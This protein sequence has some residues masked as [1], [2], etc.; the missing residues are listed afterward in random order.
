M[1]LA[2]AY[3]QII[4]TTENIAG[5]ISSALV[6][7]ASSAGDEAGESAGSALVDKIKKIVAAAGIGMA[8]KKGFDAIGDL[9]SYGDTIDK[10][11]QKI[12]ISAKAYQEWDAVLQH[13]GTSINTMQAAMKKMT[14]AAADGS[15]AFG[16]LGISQEE[17][18]SMSQE[19]LFARVIEGL[20]GMEE[21]TE[22]AALAQDLL[23][24]GA[25]EMAALL[26]TSAE[27]T[28]K[29]KDAVND[30]GGVMSDDAVKASAAYQ[31]ALQDMQTAFSGLGRSLLSEFLPGLT[32]V[33]GGIT[34]LFAG[35]GAGVQTVISGI[36]T[37]LGTFATAVPQFLQAGANIIMNVI[38]G[39]TAALPGLA[40]TGM[41][42]IPKVITGLLSQLP[43]LIKEGGNILQQFLNT[44]LSGLPSLMTGGTSMLGSVV[45]GIINTLPEIIKSAV[46]VVMSLLNTIMDNLPAILKA[47]IE[48]VTNIVTGIIDTLPDVI[49]AALEMVKNFLDQV[50]DN[51]PNMLQ[52]GTEIIANVVSG[53]ISS[54]PQI[55]ASAAS[56]AAEFIATLVSN[57]P[58]FLSK[59]VEILGKVVAGIIQAIPQIVSAAGSAMGD[60][61]STITGKLPEVLGKGKE[62]ITNLADG[63]KNNIFKIVN[64]VSSIFSDFK[65][66]ITGKD[67]GSIG[68]N[69]INGV[70]NGITNNLGKLKEAAKEAARKAFDAAKSF[71]GIKS[72]SRKF[73]WI[74]DMSA[75]GLIKGNAMN[76]RKFQRAGR[77]A[78]KAYLGAWDGMSLD[79]YKGANYLPV[80][81]DNVNADLLTAVNSLGDRISNMRM[82][83]D[84]GALVGELAEGMNRELGY[85]A[86]MEAMA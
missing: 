61:M 30:L 56:A 46:S 50:S 38:S 29:M 36:G 28:Q 53:I 54:L 85:M 70:K 1:E 84:T 83:T 67:W 64:T 59:G 69:I 41:Q 76:A 68:L 44:L 37:L 2:R 33:M 42:M 31:D 35:D 40:S 21:G 32:E 57:F 6:P 49:D 82:V 73:M 15:D 62:I 86:K 72:P 19:D 39:I 14:A 52:K 60:F 3:V 80:T 12:G 66:A 55:V 79:A 65:S 10:Q 58:R 78:A 24:R 81:G 4:P 47:G 63:V 25:Q 45:K 9:A 11:S 48:M 18:M 5:G 77:D 7:E 8:I 43:S 16:K 23:G 22:R 13:S 17:A 71:L 34:Q 74:A 51:L 75:E 26:N 27:D 20:Q